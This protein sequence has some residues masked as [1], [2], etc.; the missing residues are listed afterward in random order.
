MTFIYKQLKKHS[1]LYC[2]L[3]LIDSAFNLISLL[4]HLRT[5]G[6]GTQKVNVCLMNHISFLGNN[7]GN[8][9]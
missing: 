5:L 8:V 9:Q 2:N 3:L 4:L 7:S 6:C 1:L